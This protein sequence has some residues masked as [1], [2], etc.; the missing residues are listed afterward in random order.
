M[1]IAD[2]MG[3]WEERFIPYLIQGEEH[4][5]IDCAECYEEIVCQDIYRIRGLNKSF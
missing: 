1:K 2:V 3:S 5:N 4:D